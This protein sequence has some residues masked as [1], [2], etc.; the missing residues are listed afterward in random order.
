MWAV[1]GGCVTMVVVCCMVCS[2]AGVSTVEWTGA[3]VTTQWC[4]FESV[5]RVRDGVLCSA[6][7]L[8]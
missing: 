8:C 6:E 3:S 4:G 1:I 2:S 7:H 5:C